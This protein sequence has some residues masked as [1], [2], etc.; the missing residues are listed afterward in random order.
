MSKFYVTKYALTTGILTVNGQL[1][2]EGRAISW[3]THNYAHGEGK[4]WHRT[5]D[6][7]EKRA[8]EMRRRKITALKK[9]LADLENLKFTESA[10]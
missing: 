2:A 3:G 4:D 1:F 8:D 10:E 6:G 7:A 9:K 5:F